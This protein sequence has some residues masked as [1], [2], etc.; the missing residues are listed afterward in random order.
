MS[1]QRFQRGSPAQS[2]MK[3]QG[4]WT[5]SVLGFLF[6]HVDTSWAERF[7]VSGASDLITAFVDDDV[8]LPALLSPLT[9]ATAF[10][11]RWLKDDFT[12]PVLLY[13]NYKLRHVN[14]MEGFKERSQLFLEELNK[15][16]VSL[17][18]QRVRVSD[19]GL[20]KCFVDSGSWF[21]EA[22]ITLTVQVLGIQPSISVSSTQDH[23]TL[24]ECNSEKWNPQPEVVWRDKNGR[25][26]TSLSKMHTERDSEG[27]LR[28]SSIIPVEQEVSVFSCMMRSSA[29]KPAWPSELSIYSLSPGINRWMV[30]VILQLV[31]LVT[32]T[33]LLITQWKRME[34]QLLH[35]WLLHKQLDVTRRVTNSEWRRIIS[36]AADVIL[37]PDTAHP[38]LCLSEDGKEVRNVGKLQTVPDKPRRYMDFH[39]V[40]A[41]EAYTSGRHYWE[42]EVR[43]KIEW[44]VGIALEMEGK[45]EFCSEPYRRVRLRN[46]KEYSAVSEKVTSLLVRRKPDRIRVFLDYDEGQLSFYNAESREHLHTFTET[47]SGKLYPYL[48]PCY[49]LRGKNI[50]PLVIHPVKAIA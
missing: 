21:E 42:V 8:I 20:Y 41:R 32:V 1:V 40:Q 15:G 16:N 36:S 30:V 3:A 14:Q 44:T 38:Y 4:R 48:S 17:K 11:I 28:V 39:S 12:S 31:V 19:E 33:L 24:L 34:D 43:E 27:L 9:N 6:L 7:Q 5:L 46:E 47:F 2:A 13:Q 49:S 18:L 26:V 37:D 50:A 29:P 25:D 23:Q 22:H 35:V 45:G 10:E